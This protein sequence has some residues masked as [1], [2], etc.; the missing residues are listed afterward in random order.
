MSRCQLDDPA[1]R[2]PA[3][4]A[5]PSSVSSSR[6]GEIRSTSSW[7]TYANVGTSFAY[8]WD[9]AA[10]IYGATPRVSNLEELR[11]VL[12]DSQGTYAKPRTSAHVGALFGA[13]LTT[14]DG[15]HWQRQRA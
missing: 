15:E 10:R 13:S 6:C 2:A 5:I 9:V 8:H 14:V 1:G 12:E 4:L 3:I 11:H 7:R